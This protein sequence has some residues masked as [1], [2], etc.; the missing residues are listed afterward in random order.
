MLQGKRRHKSP[1]HRIAETFKFNPDYFETIKPAVV[2]TKWTSEIR[3]QSKD[4]PKAAA[5]QDVEA[6]R[7]DNVCIYS[8]GFGQNGNIGGVAVLQRKGQMV[9]SIRMHLGK[10]THHIVYEGK[11][12]SLILAIELLKNI[13]RARSVSLALNNQAAILASTTH[14]PTPGQY[15]WNI[16]HNNLKNAMHNH[17]LDHIKI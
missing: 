13:H 3:I 7:M 12:I 11:V 1:L 9:K 10:D 6:E 4:N 2:S 16:F 17:S 15:L 8:D 5:A 14:K